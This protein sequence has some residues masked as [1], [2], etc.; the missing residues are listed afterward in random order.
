[1]RFEPGT[2][3]FVQQVASEGGMT[4]SSWTRQ[5]VEAELHRRLPR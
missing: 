4:V 1:M 2:I 5:V 3:E